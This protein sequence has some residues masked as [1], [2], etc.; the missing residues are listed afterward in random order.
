V[1]IYINVF[2]PDPNILVDHNPKIVVQSKCNF[3]LV[4]AILF[5]TLLQLL[6]MSHPHQNI[7][8]SCM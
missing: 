6:E 7:F 1:Y 8:C 4:I 3:G 2:G 5:V